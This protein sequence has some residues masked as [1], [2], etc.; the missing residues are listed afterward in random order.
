MKN[1]LLDQSKLSPDDYRNILE[2][3]QLNVIALEECSVKM[4][5]GNM[6]PNLLISM[7][8][9][10]KYELPTKNDAHIAHTYNL[11]G[12]SGSVKD[13]ALKISC[14]FRLEYSSK[15]AFTEEFMEVFLVTNIAWNS[16]PYFREFIQ[17]MTQRMN[18]PPLVVPLLKSQGNHPKT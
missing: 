2:G 12:T 5:K 14:T 17:N 15:A 3:V 1:K 8:D 10:T 4:R 18:I 7:N 6:R 9:K 11:T 16:W 13:Y